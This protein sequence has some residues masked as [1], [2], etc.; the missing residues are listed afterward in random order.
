VNEL[1]PAQAL[2]FVIYLFGDDFFHGP[3]ESRF[4]FSVRDNASQAPPEAFCRASFA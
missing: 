1:L 2:H 4:T 3:G